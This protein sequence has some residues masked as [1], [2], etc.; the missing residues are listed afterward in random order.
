MRSDENRLGHAIKELETAGFVR[1]HRMAGDPLI[2]S[3]LIHN[4]AR[5]FIRTRVLQ[6]DLPDVL[7]TAL[8]LGGLQLYD[9]SQTPKDA[10]LRGHMGRLVEILD[11]FLERAT[12]NMLQPPDGVYFRVCAIVVPVYA[13]VCRSNG[14]FVEASDL[15]TTYLQYRLTSNAE[16]SLPSEVHL[17]DIM[18]AAVIDAK[19]GNLDNAIEKYSTVITQSESTNLQDTDI[20]I[21]ASNC[22]RQ[23]RERNKVDGQ[24]L[25]RAVTAYAAPKAVP[26]NIQND[27][28]GFDVDD[29][30][31]ELRPE[32]EY[33]ETLDNAEQPA[34]F[35]PSRE[36]WYD[37]RPYR[38]YMWKFYL[39]SQG[40]NSTHTSDALK[41]LFFCCYKAGG[42]SS[43][44]VEDFDFARGW[45]EVFGSPTLTYLFRTPLGFDIYQSL[46]AGDQEAM[47]RLLCE[48]EFG[49]AVCW[50]SLLPHPTQR[51]VMD[52][53][54][55]GTTASTRL[56]MNLLLL[57]LSQHQLSIT[58]IKKLLEM[59]AN[60][61]H[62]DAAATSALH[63]AASGS[64][65]GLYELLI[66]HG[67]NPNQ[68]DINGQTAIH[69]LSISGRNN[70]DLKV[71]FEHGAS[72]SI[73]DKSG[74]TPLHL[75]TH[76]GNIPTLETLL[77][78]G[79]DISC[80]NR[81]GQAA[82]SIAAMSNQVHLV[83]YLLDR[84]SNVLQTDRIGRSALH[85]AAHHV[86]GRKT[87]PGS[88]TVIKGLL[89]ALEKEVELSRAMTPSLELAEIINRSDIAGRTALYEAVDTVSR[90]AAYSANLFAGL[91]TVE[92]LMDRGADPR[93]PDLSGR[94]VLDIV[95]SDWPSSGHL[96]EVAH[97]IAQ[98][99]VSVDSAQPPK[100]VIPIFGISTRLARQRLPRRL[101]SRLKLDASTETDSESSDIWSQQ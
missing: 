7:A 50:A 92:A 20:P 85:Y 47:N 32:L 27:V 51:R 43:K 12:D 23:L 98:I 90:Y 36:S 25:E 40:P 82:L 11:M 87:E 95:A 70:M 30:D 45:A 53:L 10:I 13:R 39:A 55:Y 79:A 77:N 35:N 67:A 56:D 78:C 1:L 5:S 97:A 48:N 34:C 24:S 100:M 61:N 3:I 83:L 49:T 26:N 37:G 81:Q 57:E 68:V 71:L 46:I 66:A 28:N 96:T 101:W 93:I 19:V 8:L 6:T 21:R 63:V 72:V 17:E 38:E 52:H 9:G 74:Q 58:G 2:D 29:T 64:D 15:W 31:W 76:S 86:Q 75:A 73:I 62:T 69:L 60:P 91:Y 42:L 22:L 44:I 80:S 89:E 84:G 99:V 65:P 88:L 41:A 59:G 94:T 16:L 14:R 4:L 33:P 18:E 54:N